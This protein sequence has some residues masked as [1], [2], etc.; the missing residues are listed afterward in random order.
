MKAD[1]VIE[2]V[3]KLIGPIDS[4]GETHTDDKRF[5]NLKIACAL[6]DDLLA[7]IGSE[8]RLGNQEFSMKRSAK[9]CQDQ[10]G[11]WA[12]EYIRTTRPAGNKE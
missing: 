1:T 6:V 2:V 3:R 12:E 4:V 9:Y 8:S 7:E 5:E 10:I 11:Y